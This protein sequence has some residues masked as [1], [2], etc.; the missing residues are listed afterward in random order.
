MNKGPRIFKKSRLAIG[1]ALAT[2]M[3]SP[4]HAVSWEYKGFDI[5]FDSNFSIGTSIRVEDRDFSKI[6]NNN[7]PNLDW[8]GY[9]FLGDRVYQA[10]DVFAINDGVGSYSANGDLGNLNFD[11]GKAFSTVFRSTHEFEVKKEEDW[12]TWGGFFRGFYYY[13]F[14]LNNDA[15]PWQNP[16]SSQLPA[17]NGRYNICDDPNAADNACDFFRGLDAFLFADFYVGDMPVTVRLGDQVISWGES[18]FIQHGINT[19]N[20]IDVAIAR[21]PGAELRNI[22][23]P[24]GTLYGSIG[25]TDN[26]SIDAYIQYDYERSILP[27]SGTYFGTNDFAADG[28]HRNNIQLGFTGNPDINQDFLINSLNQLGDLVRGTIAA[29]GDPSSLG[30]AMLA[31]STRVAIRAEGDAFYQDAS[32]SGQY[33]IRL[34]YFADWLNDTEFS[35]QHLNYH[36][37]RPLLNGVAA[38]YLPDAI[39]RDLGRLAAGPVTPGNITELETFAKATAVF[40]EDIKLY[41]LSF[42]TNIGETSLAGEISFRPDE[43]IQMDDVTLLYTAF[44]EQLGFVHQ[45]EEANNVPEDLR[46][47]RADLIGISQFGAYS[48]IPTTPGMDIQGY[49]ELDTTQIQFTVSHLFGPVLGM[50]NFIMLGEVGYISISDMPDPSVLAL[51]APGTARSVPL[52]PTADGVSRTGLHQGLSFGPETGAQFATDDAW[53]YRLLAIADFLD[54]AAGV[55]MRVRTTFSHDVDGTTPNPLFLFTEDRKSGNVGITF[56][57]LNKYSATFSYNGFWGGGQ[58]NALADRDFVSIVFNYAI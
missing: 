43:P 40:P 52:L 51:E 17:N 22:F 5:K 20:P 13:D 23:I 31:H 45:F 57:Y 28:G 38:N 53:G 15:R 41:G 56:D 49:I 30:N 46:Y 2:A 12:G 48:G 14:E 50:D 7:Q 37:K 34:T 6:G 35:F 8:T 10:T 26:L 1:M 18:T 47:G 58:A 24:V 55:N 21:A 19:S 54:V 25:L 39:G 27:V 33:G 44:P 36:S 42:N 29:G 11:S 9:S 3:T 16:L 4:A 32:D